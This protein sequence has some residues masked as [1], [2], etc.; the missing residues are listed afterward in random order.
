MAARATKPEA[1]ASDLGFC[2]NHPDVPAVHVTDGV[3]FE[4]Q[5]YCR[6]CLNRVE[7]A[8]NGRRR[9]G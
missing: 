6:S 5:R 2:D 1:E 4:V 3:K 9:H 7:T 8:L